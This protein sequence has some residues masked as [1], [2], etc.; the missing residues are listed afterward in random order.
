MPSLPSPLESLSNALG[1]L[2]DG[3]NVRFQDTEWIDP[4]VGMG[5]VGLGLG[6]GVAVVSSQPAP[7]FATDSA[8][9]GLCLL[10]KCKLQLAQ[11]IANPKCL[12]NVICINTCSNRPDESECQVSCGNLFENEVVGEFNKCAVSSMKCVTQKPDDGSFPK[13]RPDQFR[14]DFDTTKFTGRWYISAG[15][16][17]LFDT[18]DCQTHFFNSPEPGRLFG[19]LYWRITQPDGEFFTRDTVQKFVQQRDKGLLF[20]HDNEYL[21]YKDDWYILDWEPENFVLIYYRGSNDA[22]DGYGG[23]TVYTRA[24]SLDPKLVP[25]IEQACE[26]AGI[27]WS[28]FSLTDNSCGPQQKDASILRAQWA[29]RQLLTAESDVQEQLTAVR[30]YAL[31]SVVSS[32]R[33]AEQILADLENQVVN[34]ERGSEL[35]LEKIQET[36]TNKAF[37]VG[38]GLEVYLAPFLE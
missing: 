28:D 30:G 34:F 29:K 32:E 18:F 1:R 10:N 12:A 11:C 37:D 8:K 15:L 16:N 22:W 14:H 7:A 27:K 19:K 33:G 3:V 9:V 35:Q 31:N 26:K 24:P 38:R 20:N 23:A 2:G 36:A 21:H 13:L 6:A 17:P 4:L 25:R 5:A